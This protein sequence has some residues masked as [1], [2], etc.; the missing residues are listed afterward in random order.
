ML[1]LELAKRWTAAGM[2]VAMTCHS[3]ALAEKLWREKLAIG[4]TVCL[5]D[6]TSRSKKIWYR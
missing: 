6:S 5:S 4:L 1:G 3:P 2:T